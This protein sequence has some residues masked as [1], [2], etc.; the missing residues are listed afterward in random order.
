M[1]ATKG[2]V[3]VHAVCVRVMCQT[4]CFVPEILVYNGDE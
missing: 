1:T 3:D 4:F 2:L